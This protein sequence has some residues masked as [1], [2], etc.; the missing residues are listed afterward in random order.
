LSGE[1]SEVP[2]RATGRDS[3]KPKQQQQLKTRSR[4][5]KRTWDTVI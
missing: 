2:C 1:T 5:A 3:G 4:N